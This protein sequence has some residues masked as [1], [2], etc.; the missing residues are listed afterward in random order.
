M[1]HSLIC[2]NE[3]NY[4]L[5]SRYFQPELT[6][7]ARRTYEAQLA[8]ICKQMPDLWGDRQVRKDADP[9]QSQL[10]VCES[11]FVVARQVGELRLML[12]GNEEYDE[13]ILDEIM[14]VLQAVLT[15]QL[16]KKLTE[17]S[18]LA[19]YAKVVV[20]LDEMVQQGHLE[21]A[22]EASIDQMIKLKPYPS[23]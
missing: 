22:D 13:L 21:N 18:L 3:A 12:S 2:C 8:Q 17:T 7:E 14:G 6:L 10:L 11:Q 23:K 5:L 15:T 20:A 4:V 19:N 9:V 1:L 16:D